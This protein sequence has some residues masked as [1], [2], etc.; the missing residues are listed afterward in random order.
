MPL[1][2]DTTA[3]KIVRNTNITSTSWS[4]N[5]A[6]NVLYV[7]TAFDSGGTATATFNGGSM[8]KLGSSINTTKEATIWRIVNPD[9]GNYTVAVSSFD[10]GWFAGYSISFTGGDPSN[11]DSGFNTATGT[12]TAPSVN[13][14]SIVGSKVLDIFA[15]GGDA[16]VVTATAGAGQT[17]VLDADD[18]NSWLFA[19]GSYE[20][21]A[22]TTT[23][24]WSLSASR[25]WAIAGVSVNEP[26]R[27]KKYRKH[28]N[29][30]SARPT[31]V[32]F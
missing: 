12:S 7:L 21:G 1:A 2:I 4:H 24:S 29:L 6:G 13:I 15:G 11:P 32:F 8:T 20:N 26:S 30:P 23:M 17:H 28:G 9:I 5:N 22:A 27:N 3:T 18:T 16:N 31:R 25:L 19:G 10:E 14:T